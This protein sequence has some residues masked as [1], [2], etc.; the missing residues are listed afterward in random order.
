ML[1]KHLRLEESVCGSAPLMRKLDCS[2][3]SERGMSAFCKTPV[4]AL[5]FL[6]DIIQVLPHTAKQSI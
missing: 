1:V 4:R 5:L 6:P 3:E 2:H